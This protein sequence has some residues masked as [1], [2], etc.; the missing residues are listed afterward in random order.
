MPL[1]LQPILSGPPKPFNYYGTGAD[2]AVTISSN[3]TLATTTG[4]ND[5]GV[6][7]KHYTDLTINAEV[8]LTAAHRTRIMMIYCTGD[9]SISGTLHLDKLGAAATPA[10]DTQFFRYK[11]GQTSSGSASTG[12]VSVDTLGG[13]S[14]SDAGV[15]EYDVPNAGGSG[16]AQQPANAVGNN[17][18]A[19]S[20]GA[21][22]GGGGGSGN[23]NTGPGPGGAGS[24]GIA[25]SGGSAGGGCSGAVAGNPT[26]GEDAFSNAAAGGHGGNAASNYG[27]GGG[28][29]GHPGG[30]AGVG[31]NGGAAGQEGGGGVLYLIVKGDLIIASGGVV[32]ADGGIGGV[33]GTGTDNGRAGG[34]GGGGSVFVLS[35]KSITNG[36]TIRANGGDGAA[37]DGGAGSTTSELIL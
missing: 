5:T 8:S 10:G 16:G 34:A 32:S 23:G 9:C 6:V 35:G 37:G 29:A 11:S 24:A 28:G 18:S 4:A 19:G 14:A 13:S 33:N 21:C 25:Y 20:G 30:A 2:G 15:K 3:T 12:L 17:G 1:L 36:G 22:G 31:G 27:N 26:A 7:I